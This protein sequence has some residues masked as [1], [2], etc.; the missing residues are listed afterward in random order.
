M[1]LEGS[2]SLASWSSD[3]LSPSS[4]GSMSTSICIEMLLPPSPLWLSPS[5]SGLVALKA[6]KVKIRNLSWCETW[7]NSPPASA[8]RRQGKI[9]P[10]SF[11]IS[12]TEYNK[13]CGYAIESCILFWLFCWVKIWRVY[14]C[15]YYKRFLYSCHLDE[16][17]WSFTV[18]WENILLRLLWSLKI[19]VFINLYKNSF[20]N[21][22]GV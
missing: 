19:K 13:S 22:L 20:A 6:E 15:Y 16:D 14:H 10:I 5:M 9:F 18:K 17:E 21:V 8:R 3:S 11:E 2:P 12:Y 7:I 4:G 1:C